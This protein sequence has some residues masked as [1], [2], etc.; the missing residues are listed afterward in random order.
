MAITAMDMTKT[1][2]IITSNSII[3]LIICFSFSMPTYSEGWQFTP[4]IAIEETFTDNVELT[5]DDPTSSLVSQAIVGLNTTYQS[6]LSNFSF[7]GQN[8]SAFYSHDSSL[9]DNFITAALSGESE[10]LIDGL[11]FIINA[12]IANI[13]RNEASNSLADLVNG[14]TIQAETYSTGFK[15]NIANSYYKLGSS[16]IYSVN[17]YEDG[18]GNSEGT[19]ISINSTNGNNSRTVFWD[20][21]GS[22][23]KR[24]QDYLNELRTSEQFIVDTKLGL[25]TSYDLTPFIRYYNED[26]TG[27]FTTQSQP[28][29][30][31]WGPGFRWLASEHFI[32]DVSY[33]FVKDKETSDDYIAASIQ[34]EPSER[35]SIAAGYSQ[36]FFGKSY[37]LN[38]QHRTK[39]LSNSISY[40]E[41]LEVFTRDYYESIDQGLF[42]CPTNIVVDNSSQCFDQSEQ[43]N[44]GE[45]QLINLTSLEP[46]ESDEFSLNKA[47][48]WTTSLQLART[49]FSFNSFATRRE[50]LETQVIDDTL[51]TSFTI[52]RKISAR[53]ELTFVAKYDYKVFDK[54]NPE[55]SRQE[56]HY[57]TL[58]ASYTKKLASS[59]STH[60]T[61]QHV[62]RDSNIDVYSYDEVRAIINLKKDF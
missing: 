11:D 2:K 61:I 15:Y 33:N 49:S 41:S 50:G 9:N 18:I 32:V 59:L 62:N 38:I 52:G 25:I 39:R 16:V 19:S 47:F 51:G 46:V 5:I 60:F 4:S 6:R 7:Y 43:P 10:L 36:R 1:N 44:D 30:S 29:T 34:W 28:T 40:N 8:S 35:T 48:S 23:S 57:R 20:I 27:T 3:A 55:G 53:S 58:S 26:Y 17:E 37:N 14:D 42:W 24:D 31:S 12:S 45:Y 21:V 22:F 56:D 13:S 54:D